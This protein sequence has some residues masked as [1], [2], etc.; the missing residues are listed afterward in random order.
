VRAL[1]AVE[2][3]LIDCFPVLGAPGRLVWGN[4]Q[5]GA[6]LDRWPK[7]DVVASCCAAGTPN[8]LRAS[9]GSS[10]EL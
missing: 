9:R 4:I 7:A 5:S 6:P 3:P 8:C 10:S 1:G 2:N